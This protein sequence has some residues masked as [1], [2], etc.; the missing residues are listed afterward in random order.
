[1]D[2]NA[3]LVTRDQSSAIKGILMLLIM[4]GHN[5]ILAPNGGQLFNYLY[6]FHIYGFF[7][8]PFL[9]NKRRPLD[10]N[11]FLNNFIR[12]WVPYI[13]FFLFCYFIYHLL[14]LKNGVDFLEIIYGIIIANEKT[15]K[16]IT[17][18]GFVWF[19]PA[20]FSMSLFMMLFEKTNK[21]NYLI[22]LFV[23]LLL[24][25]NIYYTRN[26]IYS[27]VPFALVQG[28]YYFTFGFL[29]KLL[30]DNVPKI[31]YI[32]AIIFLIS[33]VFYW[34]LDSKD[35][36]YIFPVSAFLFIYSICNFLSRIPFLIEIG[37]LSFPIYLV[38]VFV[39]NFFEQIL[40]NTILFGYIDFLATL[41]VS[42]LISY[43]IVK[44][45]V[46]RKLILPNDWND[47]KSFFMKWSYSS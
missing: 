9:Y 38:H 27:S 33:S 23:G 7:I 39:Y 30:L 40:P 14:L 10:K 17:G 15:I 34:F 24:N 5:H 19:L 43:L 35:M 25:F 28:F 11:L 31:K 41:I 29:T 8:L 6:S 36:R 12:M 45:N 4:L 47:F 3:S 26:Y 22:I 2:N 42:I 44:I 18:F 1:M 37:K 13:V 21:I 32:G 46:I 16:E 20:Y